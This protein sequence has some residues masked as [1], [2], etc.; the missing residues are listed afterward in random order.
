L[1]SAKRRIT[2]PLAIPMYRPIPSWN[3]FASKSH[4]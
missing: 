2:A 4:V 1:R 3:R